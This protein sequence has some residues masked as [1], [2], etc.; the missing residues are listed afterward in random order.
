MNLRNNIKVV[1][2]FLSLFV[3]FTSC[4]DETKDKTLDFSNEITFNDFDCEDLEYELYN[5]S[6]SAT[7]YYYGT[8]TFNAKVNS[9]GT[10]SGFAVSNK[11]LRSYP[12]NLSVLYGEPSSLA[13]ADNREEIDSCIYSVYTTKPN[14]LGRYLVANA[15]DGEAYFTLSEPMTV[16]RVCIANTTYNFMLINNGSVYS[17]NLN[18]ETQMYEELNEDGDAY[19]TVYN[20]NMPNTAASIY[21]VFY[22]PTESGEEMVRMD[23]QQIL[24]Q[25][26]AGAAA[27]AATLAS[28]GSATEAAADSTSVA[29]ATCFGYFKV[30]ATGYLDNSVTGT[31]DYYLAVNP[32]VSDDATYATWDIV[33]SFWASWDLSSLGKVDKVLF[34]LDSSDKDG[35]GKMRTPPYFCLDGIELER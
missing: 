4:A 31:S 20:P 15:E 2:V 1:A 32:G 28:G 29:S 7:A 30:T 8:A 10:H 5:E 21:S 18:S 6:F 14:A 22:M 9:D 24:A 11:N 17:S 33:Q 12:W 19:A 34:T 35:S 27:A 16:T 25:R 23:G 13:Y 3:G 26:A